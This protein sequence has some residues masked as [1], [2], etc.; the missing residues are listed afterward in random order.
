VSSHKSLKI[1][2]GIQENFKFENDEVKPSIMHLGAK[3]LYQVFNGVICWTMSSNK[4]INAAIETI[5]KKL[6]SEGRHL[7]RRAGTPM[8]RR[9]LPWVHNIL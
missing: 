2:N 4:Y 6:K 1:F 7:S 3:L 8:S 5:E 9:H